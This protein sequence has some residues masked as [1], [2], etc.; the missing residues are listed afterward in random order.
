MNK[1][2]ERV[3]LTIRLPEAILLELEARYPFLSSNAQLNLVLHDW[4]AEVIK[5][6]DTSSSLEGRE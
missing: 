5:Q 2:I 3:A 4:F 6:R 1:D